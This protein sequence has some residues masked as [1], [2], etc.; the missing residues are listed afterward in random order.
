MAP[1]AGVGRWYGG[2]WYNDAFMKRE[3]VLLLLVLASGACRNGST[4]APAGKT[5]AP[6]VGAG[7]PAQPVAAAQPGV[8]GQPPA[9]RPMPAAIPAVLARVNGEA[10]EK[11]EFDNAVK[12]VEAR[13]G[14]AVP[15][16]SDQRGA[17]I[18]TWRNRG[19]HMTRR[20]RL[21]LSAFVRLS[22]VH[23]PVLPCGNGVHRADQC[24]RGCVLRS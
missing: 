10:V 17:P 24:H 5:G 6:A 3:R 20:E 18:A 7:Q 23:E 14:S 8:P 4:P 13:A 15:A 9:P 16:E 19:G 11:W 22:S 1:P 2:R 12:R 21:R